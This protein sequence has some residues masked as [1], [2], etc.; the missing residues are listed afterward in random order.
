MVCS[1]ASKKLCGS[2]TCAVCLPRSFAGHERASEW[3]AK[4]PVG[5]EAVHKTSNKKYWFDC[6]GCGH[7]IELPLSRI[8]SGGWCAYC[9]R[10]KLCSSEDCDFCFQRSMASHPMGVMWSARNALK[11]REVSR[12]NDKKFWFRCADCAHEYDVV[13]Y[14]M[15]ADKHCPYCSNQALCDEEDCKGCHE[16][17]CASHDGMREEWSG[18]NEKTPRQVFL[19]S[20]RKYWFDCGK[21]GHSYSNTATHYYNRGRACPYCAN[22][23]LC[24]AE[25]CGMCFNK[26]FASHPRMTC[27]SPKNTLNPRM[28]FKGAEKRAFFVCDKCATEFDILLY[29]VLSGFWCAVCKNKSEAKVLTYLR[30]E[31]PRCKTQLR[32]KWC[33]FSKTNSIMPF[34]FGLEEEKILIELDGIQHFE[35]VSNWDSPEN[36]QA[37]DVE[38][39]VK[40]VEAGYSVIHLFQPEVWSDAYDWKGVLKEKV[41]GL[42]ARKEEKAR[43][44]FISQ[45]D[46]YGEHIKG[47]DGVPYEVVHPNK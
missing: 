11:A 6:K 26:S 2:M 12:G 4:N 34:D 46:V 36:V 1:P 45:R 44:V 3:S 14:S 5:P 28:T 39:T 7:E 31:Y 21:C 30:K 19:Q 32:Y 18:E 10:G 20:N 43:C 25:D 17:S 9:N 22:V 41:E 35:Q 15:K 8:G 40:A 38:K 24:E 27:W 33:R 47:L 37:K 42:K 23:K 13:P 29:N 16:K